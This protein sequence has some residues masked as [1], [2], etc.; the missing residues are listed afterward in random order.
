MTFDIECVVKN[1]LM[2]RN[3]TDGSSQPFRSPAH[4]SGY[5]TGRTNEE[6]ER[7][8]RHARGFEGLGMNRSLMRTM[9]ATGLCALLL[10]ATLI[11]AKAQSGAVALI[12]GVN[13]AACHPG[14]GARPW[15]DSNQTPECRALEV[16][17]QMTYDEKL[18]FGGYFGG[19]VKRLGLISPP[20]SDGPNGVAGGGIFPGPLPPRSLNVTAFPT[21]ITLAATWDRS[22]AKKFGEA[23]GQEFAGKG[24]GSVLGPTVNLLRTWHWGRSAETFGEDPYLMSQL[25]VPEIIGIQSQRVIAVV[26]HFDAN[27]Q[28]YGRTGV[29]PEFAGIDERITEK[30][31][32]EIYFPA[33]KAAIQRAHNGGIMCA[34]DRVNGE[35]SCNNAWLLG[36]LRRWGF[37]GYIDP[38]AV[39][40]QRSVLAAANAGVDALSPPQE[41][42]KLIKSGRLPASILDP[43]AFHQLVPN[44]RVGIYDH[45]ASGSP[46]ANVS[47]PAHVQL[48]QEIAADGAVLL[49]NS[50]HVLP[51][52]G[53]VKS[54]AVIGDDAGPDATVMETGSAA[55]HVMHLS[56]PFKAIRA[57]AGNTVEVIYARG[58]LGIGPLPTIPTDALTP[59]SGN[60]GHGL[61]ARYYSSGYW[62]GK[63]VVARVDPTIDFSGAPVSQFDRPSRPRG[64]AGFARP[65]WSAQWTGTITPPA[66]GVYRFSVTCGGTAQLYVDNKTVVS[67]MRADFPT[68]S[69]GLVDLAANH[70]VPIALKYSSASNLLGRG[71]KVGWQPP[72]P[73][74]LSAAVDAARKADV[75][76]VFASEQMGEGHDDLSLDLPG[77][78][79]RLIEAVA[80]ANRRTIIVLNTSNPV[81]MPWL[82]QVSAVIEA[83]YPGQQAGTSIASLLFGDVDPS[84]K[85]PVTFPRDAR[86]GPARNFLEYP[87]DGHTV[88]FD[89]GVLVGYR[90]YDAKNQPPLFPFGFGLSYT[91]FKY[92]KLRLSGAG[93]NRS[94]SVT[95]TNTGSRNGAEVAQL[96]VGF[97]EAAGEPPRQLKG[98]EKVFLKPGQSKSV[99]FTLDRGALSA[100]NAV[101]GYWQTYDGEYTVGVGSSS[102]DIRAKASFIR[103]GP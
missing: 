11:T 8:R 36:N 50:A 38:D 66:T 62:Y 27:D 57:R 96:Y 81:S 94:V 49:K 31:L 93:T 42:D 56:V 12:P 85:L 74:M 39:F 100:W 37:D 52:T 46:N 84:G 22:L 17:A 15:T 99:T 1:N 86:Q 20:G 76:I 51:L 48:A 88:N 3:V 32:Q 16:I 4:P 54:I 55:V 65:L 101:T 80:K 64:A 47:T 33:F 7:I 75:A 60:Q 92:S 10:A 63:P 41:L 45:P 102:R 95:I 44:F 79:D 23:V 21:V 40:A 83:W 98:F 90:W 6:E 2:A 87:G 89:E 70:A 61:L 72:D 43:I 103:T 68:T 9:L 69:Q 5:V 91:T 77:D 14:P 78:Q 82:D 30:A 97:P 26:K 58:T 18:H 28:E 73:T 24:M 25:V 29:N 19:S 67:L 59:P 13:S 53:N 34:Y 35:F 71:I